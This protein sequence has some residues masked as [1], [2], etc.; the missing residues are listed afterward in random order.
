MSCDCSSFSDLELQREAISARIRKTPELTKRLFRVDRTTGEHSLYLCPDCGQ[1]WQFSMAW[2]WGNK[3]YG[4]RVPAIELKYWLELPF[5]QPD[6][7]LLFSAIMSD[8][9]MKQTW[10]ASSDRCRKADCQSP[11]VRGLVLC[12]EHHIR[13]LQEQSMLPKEPIG[14]WFPP[15]ELLLQ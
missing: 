14:R 7:M 3:P 10:E 12:R 1:Q 4:F 5:I 6:E 8:F 15:Y 13:S 9:L 2:N 11:A